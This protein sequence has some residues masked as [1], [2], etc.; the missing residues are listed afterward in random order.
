MARL[1]CRVVGH[2]IPRHRRFFVVGLFARCD[3]CG[4]RVATGS[5]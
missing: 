3:R 1:V 4:A 5:H 2:K